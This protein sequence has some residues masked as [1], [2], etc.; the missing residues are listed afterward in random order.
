M[1]IPGMNPF[2]RLL[3]AL[4]ILAAATTPGAAEMATRVADAK[5]VIAIGGSILEVVY[6]LGEE[7]RLIARDSTGV[8]P[9]P[10]LAL[11]DV[12][13]M[14][15]LSP[16]NVLALGPDA[17]VALKGSGPPEAVDVLK[18]ASVP[19]VEIP[20]GYD[21]AGILRKIEHVGAALGVPDKAAALAGDVGGQLR[22]VEALTAGIEKHKRVLFILSFQD[23][24]I[25][26]SGEGTAASGIL[27]L[28]GADNAVSGFQGYKALSDEAVIEA[29]PDVI[30][31][32]DRGGGD[33][34][35]LDSQ[36]L[37]HPAIASTPAGRD[38]AIIRMDGA[39]LL[40]F[41]PRTAAAARDLA[42][43]LYGAQ[44]KVR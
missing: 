6:A 8:Y 16:E 18:K 25:L 39:Y 11:P 13:Y 26:G 1:S 19:Y 23:G 40:G 17:I 10:A 28:A 36:L 2:S 9:P 43:A 37:A 27:A 20:D 33:H 31:M 7:G 29:A 24:K 15:A 12:G 44:A 3:A 30:L 35:A 34:A 22:E 42:A 41:G 38:K 32:M 21:R 4:A 14:R 5:R